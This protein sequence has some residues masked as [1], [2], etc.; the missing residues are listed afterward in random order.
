MKIV[1][2]SGHGKHIRGA[3]GIIDEV[4]EARKVVDQV[5]IDLA[6]LGV[7]VTTYH[8][9]ISDDQS[10][11]LNRIV[12]FHNAQGP[13]D[14]DVSVHFNAYEPTDEPM[15]CEVLHAGSHGTMASDVS[16]T[17]AFVAGFID[18]GAKVREDLFFLN[19]T[20]EP[21]ILIETCFVDS[22]ADVGQYQNF[23]GAICSAIAET[24]AGE[25]REEVERPEQPMN[26]VRFYGKCSHFG[27]PDDMGVDADEGLAFIYSYEQAPHLFLREQPP[28]TSGLARRLDPEVYYVACRWDYYSTPKDMLDDK[29]KLALVRAKNGETRL[30]WPSD[31]GPHEDTGRAADISPGL[32]DSLEIDTDDEIEVIYPI[33]V[34]R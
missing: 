18:R 24:L 17:M 3:S 31:W 8:D 5:A 6:E 25:T 21:A 30:A 22:S 29:D 20:N 34:E 12:D 1:L 16:A 13:H 23:F 9:D 4:D 19:S 11:N 15:G 26:T 33:I 7:D 14:W 32:M 28:G 27:G 2:S 10:E